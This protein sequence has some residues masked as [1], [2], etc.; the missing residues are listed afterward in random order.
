ME[1]S[2]PGFSYI[3]NFLPSEEEKDLFQK[4]S[5]GRWTKLANRR[6]QKIGGTV[7]D[8]GRP[9]IRTP[10]PE[11]LQKVKSKIEDF[12][13]LEGQ[14]KKF[15]IEIVEEMN[16]VLINEYLPG[17]GIM[18]HTDGPAYSS[19]V[20]TI[21]TGSGQ[22]LNIRKKQNKELLYSVYL[23]PGA[24]SIL[25]G[26]LYNELHEIEENLSDDISS[27]SNFSCL[28]CPPEND[29]FILPRQTR[30]SFTFRNVRSTRSLPK[31]FLKSL[32]LTIT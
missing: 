21:S 15:Q 28:S 23:E 25:H 16:H 13:Q 9:M 17:Q 24:L 32:N 22:I 30:I 11:Y 10:F 12:L 20:A 3:P 31:S 8:D 6:L 26:R 5:K 29:N 19:V 4:A 1:W 2:V 7:P 18:A 27:V 14:R